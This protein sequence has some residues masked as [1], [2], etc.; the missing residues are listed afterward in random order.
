LWTTPG[1]P[2]SYG[3]LIAGELG[4]KLQIVGHDQTT[5]GGWDPE[6]GKR[7]WTLAAASDQD[8]NVP[9]PIIHRGR[10]LVTTESDGTRVY[11]FD[12]EGQIVQEPRARFADLAPDTHTPVVAGDRLFGV[13][14]WLYCLDLAASLKEVYH[15]KDDAFRDHTSLIATDDKLLVCS[16]TG[17]LILLDAKASAHNVLGRLQV[18]EDEAGLLSHPALVG[19]KLYIRGSREIVCVDL[20]SR[21]E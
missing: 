17:E 15:A 3:S 14:Q 2:A 4:G 18:F 13:S 21:E 20:G 7:L 9:T 11:D 8:F 6:T 19:Q 12:Q 5:L 10:L 1:K 16:S